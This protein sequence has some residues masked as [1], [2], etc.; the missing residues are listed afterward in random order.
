M[1]AQ[2]S[3]IATTPVLRACRQ[4]LLGLGAGPAARLSLRCSQTALLMLVS[5]LRDFVRYFVRRGQPTAQ[6]YS[7]RKGLA[8][9]VVLQMWLVRRR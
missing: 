4:R 7:T 5:K 6:I 3:M 8:R 2:S 9:R 1:C